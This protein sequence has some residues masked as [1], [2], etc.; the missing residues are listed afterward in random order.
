LVALASQSSDDR[1]ISFLLQ[2]LSVLVQRYQF[3]ER[4]GVKFIPA[5]CIFFFTDERNFFIPWE[6]AVGV[7][8]IIVTTKPVLI[9]RSWKNHKST[10]NY[11]N[12][13]L[14]REWRID[15]TINNDKLSPATVHN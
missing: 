9:S 1:D 15:M 14:S 3:C 12:W 13:Q 5:F 6:L 10:F 11:L 2:R 8:Q 4:G 7:K